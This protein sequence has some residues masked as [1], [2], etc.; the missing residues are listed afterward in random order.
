MLID[1]CRAYYHSARNFLNRIQF[2]PYWAAKWPLINPGVWR[3]V[4]GFLMVLAI[5]RI[6]ARFNLESRIW[7]W[8]F[9]SYN[10]PSPWLPVCT[11]LCRLFLY[12]SEQTLIRV[13]L[14]RSNRNLLHVTGRV[15]DVSDLRQL[16]KT[17]KKTGTTASSGVGNG[18][19]ET[20]SWFFIHFVL[21]SYYAN[22]IGEILSL[23]PASSYSDQNLMRWV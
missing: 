18:E 23:G 15:S 6:F 17:S 8:L 11:L 9:W 5:K 19:K 13:S 12:S 4:V 10:P 1:Q 22:F 7:L 2:H 21:F 16:S 14:V 3:S 20:I